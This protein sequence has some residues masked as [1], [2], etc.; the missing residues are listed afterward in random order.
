MLDENE[1][2]GSSE[3]SYSE[4]NPLELKTKPEELSNTFSENPNREYKSDNGKNAKE[5]FKI[6][7]SIVGERKS[8][9]EALDQEGIY[10]LEYF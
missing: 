10:L 8:H 1:H 4:Y 9:Y 7:G 5:I 2:R 6:N 3:E